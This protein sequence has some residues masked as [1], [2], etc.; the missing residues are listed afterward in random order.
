MTRRKTLQG[1]NVFQGFYNEYLLPLL[2]CKFQA[3]VNHTGITFYFYTLKDVIS[4]SI[5]V[6]MA[7]L[8]PSPFS[9]CPQ[10][11]QSC[12]RLPC[13]HCSGWSSKATA[14]DFSLSIR[15]GLR[16]T[17]TA[18]SSPLAGSLPNWPPSTGEW[19]PLSFA[20]QSSTPL[21]RDVEN[22][23]FHWYFSLVILAV[24][25]TE[26]GLG[27]RGQ[28]IQQGLQ[29]AGWKVCFYKCQTYAMPFP[30]SQGG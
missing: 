19:T 18:Q 27:S 29:T 8:L 24:I 23:V 15:P 1:S 25:V 13:A 14:T 12:P 28:S 30:V 6:H 10:P 4:H 20:A 17:S 11:C 2:F 5:N 22:G 9:L 3:C 7:S 26:T 21:E 16:L